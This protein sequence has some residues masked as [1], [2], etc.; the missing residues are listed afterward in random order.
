MSSIN[1]ALRERLTFVSLALQIYDKKVTVPNYIEE[2]FLFLIV[3]L[4]I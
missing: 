1:R 4:L 2:L 3:I